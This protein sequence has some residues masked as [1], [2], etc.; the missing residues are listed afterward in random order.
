M[1]STGAKSFKMIASYIREPEGIS[2]VVDQGFR[3]GVLIPLNAQRRESRSPCL[4]AIEMSTLKTGGYDEYHQ[5][6][7]S[8]VIACTLSTMS[9]KNPNS[10]WNPA[11]P[12]QVTPKEYEQ[13]VVAWLRASGSRLEKFEVKH[14][15]H[16]PGG[17]GDYEFDAVAEFTILNGACIIVLVECKRHSRPVER[18]YVLALWAKLLD[19]NAHKAMIFAT[20]GFQSGALQYARSRNIATVTFT[21]GTFAYETKILNGPQQLPPRADL[22]PWV[23]LPRFVGIFVRRDDDEV[24]RCTRIDYKTE[25]ITEWLNST[26][27]VG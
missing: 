18:D 24:I 7:A 27:S 13:Q 10:L 20:C 1:E 2:S 22:P 8:R 21:E 14:L 4:L 9:K 11:S 26:E 3:C 6:L 12:P 23:D 16:L 25:L 15:K 5:R 19:V 17:G